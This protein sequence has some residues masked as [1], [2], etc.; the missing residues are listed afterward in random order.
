[1]IN[2]VAVSNLGMGRTPEMQAAYQ[3]SIDRKRALYGDNM[4]CPF[5]RGIDGGLGEHEIIDEHN[6][7]YIVQNAFPYAVDNGQ[8]VLS[9]VMV[10]PHEHVADV[11]ELPKKEAK[12][13]ND[14]LTHVRVVMGRTIMMRSNRDATKSVVHAHAHGFEYGPRV[15]F[16]HYDRDANEN[17][18]LFEGEEDKIPFALGRAG[19]IITHE[20]A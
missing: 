11:H 15:I 20:S 16:Q 8:E 5:D 14:A 9:H 3:E 4:P 2:T 19:L 7:I 10:V 1:M 17:I 13:F 18:F 6:G 12:A